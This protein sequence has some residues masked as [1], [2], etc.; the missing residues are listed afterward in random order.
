[1]GRLLNRTPR[2][3]SSALSNLQ[4]YFW[5]A[6]GGFFCVAVNFGMFDAERL[7]LMFSQ[8]G[9][10]V[11]QS[12]VLGIVMLVTIA[13]GAIWARAHT[14]I[15]SVLVVLQLGLVAPVAITATLSQFKDNLV[16]GAATSGNADTTDGGRSTEGFLI[17]TANATEIKPVA[18]PKPIPKCIVNT[19]I[20]K[21]C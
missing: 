5:G 3:E 8:T 13:A 1:M 6:I 16:P 11:I 17:G 10:L 4:L 2:T 21:P 14:P 12:I 7:Q 15:T 19:I 18:A 9:E 20:L